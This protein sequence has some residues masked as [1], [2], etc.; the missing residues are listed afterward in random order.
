MSRKAMFRRPRRF[1]KIAL[2]ALGLLLAVAASWYL[3]MP[4]LPVEAAQARAIDRSPSPQM[5][6]RGVRRH[7][8]I[9]LELLRNADHRLDGA[10]VNNSHGDP[11]GFVRRVEVARDGEPQ[12][13][14]VS[15]GGFL[16]I[17]VSVVPVEADHLGYDPKHNIVLT[18][19]TERQLE[20][21]AARR[22]RQASAD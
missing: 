11:V 6:Y 4:G 19:M 7:G 15:F 20:V 13:V 16:G 21:I 3:A 18:D 5:P 2:A 1:P 22:E 8:G 17:G 10:A 12:I 9:P 14:D